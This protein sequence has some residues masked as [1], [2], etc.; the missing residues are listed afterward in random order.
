MPETKSFSFSLAIP[1][2]GIFQQMHKYHGVAELMD[3]NW[4]ATMSRLPD[5]LPTNYVS[6][7]RQIVS[8]RL[9]VTMT[10]VYI[11]LALWGNNVNRAR[12][13]RRW[14][15]SAARLS[16][17]LIHLHNGFQTGFSFSVCFKAAQL[18]IRGLP[19]A[20]DE[21]FC[22][23]MMDYLCRIQTPLW[24]TGKNQRGL[25]SDFEGLAG[26]FFLSKYYDLL[27]SMIIFATGR[28]ISGLH[29]FHHAGVII[30]SCLLWRLASP[31]A[32]IGV[33]LN[34]GYSFFLL[35]GLHISV[36]LA[37]K[38]WLTTVQIGQFFIGW[39]LACCYFFRTI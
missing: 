9:A 1:D 28:Y 21:G 3:A 31:H 10:A 12:G 18:I 7:Y 13:Y 6:Y 23:Q 17:L 29:I 11:S 32:I 36:P 30:W 19:E 37:A 27:D 5:W 2:R 22:V 39:L 16:R 34:S 8:L 38:R 15:W 4:N 24:A 14:S 25:W 33:L 35:R 26:V 20:R